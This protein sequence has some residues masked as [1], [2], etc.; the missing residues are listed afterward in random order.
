MSLLR[1]PLRIIQSLFFHYSVTAPNAA[2]DKSELAN[3]NEMITR[4]VEFH[5]LLKVILSI[6]D[7]KDLGRSQLTLGIMQP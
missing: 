5:D 1:I 4:F 6:S 3:P 2:P 7:L